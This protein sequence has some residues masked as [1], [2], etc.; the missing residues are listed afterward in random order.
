MLSYKSIQAWMQTSAGNTCCATP[1]AAC[2]PLSGCSA[3][4]IQYHWQRSRPARALH[5]RPI[6]VRR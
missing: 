5:T 2:V 1:V 4:A 6:S 3:F